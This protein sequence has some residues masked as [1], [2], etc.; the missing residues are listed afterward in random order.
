[1]QMYAAIGPKTK[2]IAKSL[3][4]PSQLGLGMDD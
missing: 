4:H 2:P 3:P 1:M